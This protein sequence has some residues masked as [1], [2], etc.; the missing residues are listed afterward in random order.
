MLVPTFDDTVEALRQEEV[1][2][3]FWKL[4][5][6]QL[7]LSDLLDKGL[8]ELDVRVCACG[9]KLHRCPFIIRSEV[10]LHLRNSCLQAGMLH[11]HKK[12]ARNVHVS[13]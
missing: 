7:I 11:Y 13:M 6:L 2:Q 3:I 1:L 12:V 8:R 10:I 5:L 9:S 4:L